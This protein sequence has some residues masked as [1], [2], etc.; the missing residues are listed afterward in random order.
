METLLTDIRQSVRGLG[1]TP[2]FTLAAVGIL[3]LGIAANT[4]VFSVADAV[5][6]RP[7]PYSHPEQ[8]VL[9]NEMI[10]KL[11]NL[12]P[13]LPVNAR[14]FYAWKERSRSFADMAILSDDGVDITAAGGPPE[15]LGVESVSFNLLPVL[16]VQ[17]LIGRNFTAQEDHPGSNRVVILTEPLWRRRFHS[18]PGIL[19]QTIVLDGVPNKVIGVLPASFRFLNPNAVNMFGHR[20][21]P[22][23]LFR[24]IAF[25]K[26]RLEDVEGDYNYAV[27]GRL[28]PGIT[29]EQA[30]AEMNALQAA[31]D[32]EFKLNDDLRASIAPLQAHIVSGSRS[33]LLMLLWSIAAV[34][35]IVCVNLGNLMLARTTARGRE[36]AVRSALGAGSW[37][38]V[39]QVLTES[40]VISFSGGL[41]G[42]GL[43][44]AAVRFLVS[45]APVDIPRLDEVHL[46]ARALLFA[47]GASMLAGLL[48]GL[49]PSW[50]ASRSEP[51]DALRSG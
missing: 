23:Q 1:R 13:A 44:Y 37:R 19:N 36:M 24:P 18:D 47:F 14:H 2:G 41:L 6:F 15:R 20:A 12:Y 32:R 4:A 9:L 30:L 8:L 39:R 34:L 51:Q 26:E 45:A 7:L 35:L 38:I 16:G 3:A 42:V 29:H 46:D 40:L 49:I 28:R 50:R 27:I 22:A 5:L 31:L 17:P 33:G 43:A 25:S 10:P 11:S 48:F 21:P